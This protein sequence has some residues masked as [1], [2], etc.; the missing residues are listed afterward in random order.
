MQRGPGTENSSITIPSQGPLTVATTKQNAFEKASLTSIE[1]GHLNVR[2]NIADGHARLSPVAGLDA[3]F[4]L[5]SIANSSQ[6]NLE[7]QFMVE[8][9][10]YGYFNERRFLTK[11]NSWLAP[12]ASAAIDAVM[13]YL[14]SYGYRSLAMLEPTFDNIPALARRA[15]LEIVAIQEFNQLP[16]DLDVDAVFLVIPNNPTGWIPAEGAFIKMATSLAHRQAPLIIDRTF[17]FFEDAAYLERVISGVPNLRWVTI[18]DTGKTWSTLENKVSVISSN[19]MGVIDDIRAIG[20]EITLNVSPIALALCTAAIRL[21]MGPS[22]IRSVVDTNRAHL[23]RSIL[24]F[25][26]LVHLHPSRLS[27]AALHLDHALGVSGAELAARASERGSGILPGRQFYWESPRRGDAIV[28]V[29]LARDIEFFEG[30]LAVLEDV[31]A[32]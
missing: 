17:R 11:Q 18:D 8:F 5:A 9:A 25:G 4:S 2:A 10:K 1:Y 24:K 23:A 7:L 32:I 22:R 27:V 6:A 13:K 3:F 28:R 30:A 16:E 14:S 19:E 26:G 29:A 12:S 21:E 20:E 31:L 15:G